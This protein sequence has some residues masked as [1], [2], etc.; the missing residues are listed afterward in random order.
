MSFKYELYRG[1]R[2]LPPRTRKGNRLWLARGRIAGT[3]IERALCPGG[4]EAARA[5]VDAYL[6]RATRQSRLD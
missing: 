4:I 5:A 2:L 1:L 6:D 3:D